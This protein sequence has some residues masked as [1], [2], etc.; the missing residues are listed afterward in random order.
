VDF[1]GVAGLVSPRR[2]RTPLTFAAFDVLAVSGNSLLDHDQISRREVLDCLVRLS[3]GALTAVR[4]V[5]GADL[6]HVLAACEHLGLEGVALKRSRSIY[7]PGQRSP[8][9][10][11]LK[12]GMSRAALRAPR[13]SL[14][15]RFRY[16]RGEWGTTTRRSTCCGAG[17]TLKS[18]YW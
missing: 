1:Y 8:D 9:W 3:D 16:S 15:A 14:S 7:P 17:P 18:A 6:D 11:K 5:P 10:R 2:R 4:Q 13:Q 12:C